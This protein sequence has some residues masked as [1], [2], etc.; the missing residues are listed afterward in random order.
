MLKKCKSWARRL[1][2]VAG[3]LCA[4]VTVCTCD[5]SDKVRVFDSSPLAPSYSKLTSNDY[6]DILGATIIDK[7]VNF[8]VY[9]KNATRI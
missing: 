5:D 4:T 7:G 6:F 8:A 9:S 1:A 2:L 3:L